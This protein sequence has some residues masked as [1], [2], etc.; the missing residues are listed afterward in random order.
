MKIEIG[1]PIVAKKQLKH[2]FKFVIE[3]MGGDA[4]ASFYPSVL[5]DYDNPYLE[6]FLEFLSKCKNRYPNGKGG[7]DDYTDVK[8]YWLFC[9]EAFPEEIEI[10][11]EF[12]EF[13]EEMKV[14]YELEF[15]KCGIRF[16]WESSYEYFGISSYVNTEVTYFDEN[17]IA[18][19]CKIKEG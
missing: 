13:T 8:D 4:D 15:K 14:E 10:D 1:K 9:G 19:E 18:L 7:Y 17:G 12:V 6:R 11:G 3:L 2:K 16:E 5:V